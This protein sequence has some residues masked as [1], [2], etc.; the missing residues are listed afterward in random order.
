MTSFS[1]VLQ[2]S[3]KVIYRDQTSTL[4]VI[5]MFK[6][7]NPILDLSFQNSVIFISFVTSLSPNCVKLLK[8]VQ[9]VSRLTKRSKSKL[10][11]TL[12]WRVCFWDYF[13][14]ILQLWLPWWSPWLKNAPK[15]S[16]LVIHVLMLTATKIKSQ[17]YVEVNGSFMEPSSQKFEVLTQ[18][19]N[20]INSKLA[21]HLPNFALMM[22]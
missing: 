2:K 12:K 22:S 17:M 11:R 8:V 3:F 14:K 13:V 15:R 5:S 6:R 7:S 19:S 10:N 1:K 18:R 4:S 21:Q 16:E 20:F 9:H